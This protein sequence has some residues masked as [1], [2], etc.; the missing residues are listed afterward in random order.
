M[1]LNKLFY[2]D[3]IYHQGERLAVFCTILMSSAPRA[4]KRR[5][6]LEQEPLVAAWDGETRLSCRS[7]LTNV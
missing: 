4:H 3:C 1:N 7:L 6:V 5:D 2:T